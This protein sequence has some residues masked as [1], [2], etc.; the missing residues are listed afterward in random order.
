MKKRV[1]DVL[2]AGKMDTVGSINYDRTI[3]A[4]SERFQMSA[5]GP[6]GPGMRTAPR[7]K[8]FA[9]GSVPPTAWKSTH[10]RA[11]T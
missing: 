5:S 9:C 3:H 10:A 4:R 2:T 1:R 6:R 11:Y 8:A 7:S